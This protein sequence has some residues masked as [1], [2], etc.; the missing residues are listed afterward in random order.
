MTIVERDNPK[1]INGSR[2]KRIAAGCGRSVQDVN[3]L[4]KQFTQM[5]KMMRQMTKK[6]GRMPRG[7]PQMPG[8]P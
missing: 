6:S 5:Q 1:V 7:F 2:R 4:L 3:R 8:M